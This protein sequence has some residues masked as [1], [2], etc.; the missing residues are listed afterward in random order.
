MYVGRS[1]SQAEMEKYLNE[2]SK[3]D[4]WNWISCLK[5]RLLSEL[6]ISYEH[7]LSLHYIH[8]NNLM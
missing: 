7:Q 3:K 2:D 6:P 4:F 1:K 8:Y 5:R